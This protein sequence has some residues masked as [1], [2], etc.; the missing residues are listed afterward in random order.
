MIKNSIYWCLPLALALSSCNNG[1]SPSDPNAVG[2]IELRVEV[3]PHGNLTRGVEH[4][5]ETGDPVALALQSAVVNTYESTG[6]HLES[7]TNVVFVSADDD[8]DDSDDGTS[9]G[10]TQSSYTATLEI[11]SQARKVKIDFNSDGGS[12]SPNVNTRQ[13]S[14]EQAVVMVS[15]E[16]DILGEKVTVVA[17][18]E[19]SRLQVID[20]IR[21]ASTLSEEIWE[22]K[23]LT[24]QGFY[25]NRSKILRTDLVADRTD[26]S[27]EAWALA[28]AS[29]GGKYSLFNELKDSD[30]NYNCKITNADGKMDF[31]GS[32]ASMN[33]IHFFSRTA[34]TDQSKSYENGNSQGESIGFNLF[35]QGETQSTEE[36]ARD[37]QPHLIIKIGYTEKALRN[38]D[39][40]IIGWEHVDVVNGLAGDD[41][42]PTNNYS[43][44]NIAAYINA[45]SYYPA[46]EAGKVYE[47]SM[48]DLIDAIAH[49]A[50]NPTDPDNPDPDSEKTIEVTIKVDNWKEVGV[51]PEYPD[52]PFEFPSEI[53]DWQYQSFNLGGDDGGGS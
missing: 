25:L 3:A 19:M 10:S 29:S 51:T 53:I 23:N 1:D 7:F 21:S 46:F 12:L 41:S 42:D 28:F 2:T 14:V 5:T 35:P 34:A 47:I 36:A 43:Y 6:R 20:D 4:G 50:T 16:A 52:I 49:P 26:P 30:G 38:A 32:Y 40:E 44:I 9:S 17:N 24:I 39:G 33:T 13:G 11:L 18:P 45:T 27:L 37:E 8:S 31:G 22:Y 15:G 48:M